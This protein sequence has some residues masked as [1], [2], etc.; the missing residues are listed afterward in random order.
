MRFRVVAFLLFI[1]VLPCFSQD[2]QVKHKLVWSGGE[3]ALRFQ[4]E[5]ERSDNGIFKKYSEETTTAHSL[6]ISLPPGEYRFRIITYDILDRQHEVTA[7]KNFV[8][9]AARGNADASSTVIIEEVIRENT[10]TQTVQNND[11]WYLGKPIRDIV[12]YG[13]KN[14]SMSE[15]DGLMNPF[16]GRIFTETVFYEITGRLYAL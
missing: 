12:F 4:I 3:N 6:E 15:L 16:K 11:D 9:S 10:R 5:I 8:V 14:I 1:A 13:L 2:I 7:W